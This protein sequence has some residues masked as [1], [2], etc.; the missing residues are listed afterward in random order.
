[1][2]SVPGDYHRGM[3]STERTVPERGRPIAEVSDRLGIPVPTIRSWERR[4]G[5]PVPGRTRGRH[6]R[7]DEHEIEQ[8]RDLR[9]LVTRGVAPAD[10]VRFLRGDGRAS[11]DRADELLRSVMAFDRDGVLSALDRAAAS[12]GVDGAIGSVLLPSMHEVGARW[13]A[14]SCDVG[15]E[16]FA[17]EIVRGW[18]AHQTAL[19]QPHGRRDHLVLACGPRDLHTI[20]LE[21]FGVVLARRGW[22]TRI[23]G[24]MTPTDPLVATVRAI[25]ARAA[26]VTAQR[27]VTRKAAIESINAVAA[28]PGVRAFYA[29]D[30]FALASARQRIRGVYL[31]ADVVAA[32]DLLEAELAGRR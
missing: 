32:A 17:T 5:F 19:A 20:G 4:Y 11:V 15:H 26:I 24:A 10:A 18:L 13:K 22:R 16:H 23:L 30:G 21:A 7:Y 28:I 2:G 6:R 8:L 25:R 31:G 12:L 1:M 14:G 27:S 9:D 3:G 29:G